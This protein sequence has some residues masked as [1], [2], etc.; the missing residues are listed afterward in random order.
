ME[1]K[2]YYALGAGVLV[3]ILLFVTISSYFGS[4]NNVTTQEQQITNNEN[5]N[6]ENVVEKKEEEISLEF[7]SEKDENEKYSIEFEKPKNLST[8]VQTRIDDIYKERKQDFL[9]KI[10]DLSSLGEGVKY[11]LKS[12]KPEVYKSDKYVSIFIEFYE[13]VGTAHPNRDFASVSYNK[14]NKVVILEDV[15]ECE[16]KN[17]LSNYLSS[18]FQSIVLNNLYEEATGVLD[19][20]TKESLKS[21]VNVGLS[22]VL[23]NFSVW[24]VDGD[25]LTFVFPAYQ[26]APYVYG[27]QKASDYLNLLISSLNDEK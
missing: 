19:E 6:N 14:D 1:E 13:N 8:E 24:Y 5:A 18:H 25:K 3:I 15:L 4:S 12:S 2:Q 21:S 20:E 11:V 26:V 9:D 23:E 16:D 22:P 27:E 17:K 10:N 7:S